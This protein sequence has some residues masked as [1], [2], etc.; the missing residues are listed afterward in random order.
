MGKRSTKPLKR[1]TYR[2]YASNWARMCSQLDDYVLT[3]NEVGVTR[4]L[5]RLHRSVGNL[6]ERH[7][8]DSTQAFPR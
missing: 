7:A 8:L 2:Q 3:G 1:E 5:N 6:R 4:T